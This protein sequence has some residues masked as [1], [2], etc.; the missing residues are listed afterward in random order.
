[1]KPTQDIKS[2]NNTFKFNDSLFA[3][4]TIVVAGIILASLFTAWTD[5][6]LMPGTF[7]KNYAINQLENS[8]D[9]TSL[10]NEKTT[11]TKPLIGIVAGHSGHDSGAVCPDGLTEVSINQEIA[12]YVQKNLSEHNLDIEILKEF[13]NRL[14]GY[15]ALALLSIHADSCEYINDQATGFKVASALSNYHPERSAR[16]VACLRHRYAQS[17]GLSL[18]NSITLDMTSYH[19]FDEIDNQTTAAII[20]VGF[21]NLDKQLLTQNPE[22]VAEGISNGIL[23]FVNN[24]DISTTP[25]P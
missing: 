20:E 18:H 5:P 16:L 19:A 14:T 11:R 13:D 8:N 17:T 23:C 2:R 10:N 6:G 3:I 9:Q 25:T 4:Q 21:M 24:E 7:G 22:K 1:M 15:Q 12:A